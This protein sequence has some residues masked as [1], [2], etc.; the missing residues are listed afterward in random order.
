MF[1]H[2]LSPQVDYKVHGDGG[3]ISFICLQIPRTWYTV[4]TQLIYIQ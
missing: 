2:F 4:G 3:L 1:I